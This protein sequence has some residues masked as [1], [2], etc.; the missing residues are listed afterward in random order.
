MN[1]E[2]ILEYLREQ[3]PGAFEGWDEFETA[4]QIR[5]RRG[6]GAMLVILYNEGTEHAVD[7]HR[8]F[9]VEFT[10]GQDDEVIQ[11]GGAELVAK[12][13]EAYHEKT[14]RRDRR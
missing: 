12:Y 9:L 14:R 2:N 13:N 3:H 1:D 5:H 10:K 6:E 4:I 8:A 7:L 11:V